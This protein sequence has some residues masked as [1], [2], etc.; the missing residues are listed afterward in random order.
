MQFT[1]ANY[2]SVLIVSHVAFKFL[3]EV[4]VRRKTNQNL[5]I[6]AEIII[7]LICFVSSPLVCVCVMC[8][9]K[10][11]V[12]RRTNKRLLVYDIEF[13]F[14]KINLVRISQTFPELSK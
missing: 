7:E 11:T 13:L 1:E 2:T 9:C 3:T 8:V 6:R 5:P 4:P 14:R 10:G 12:L